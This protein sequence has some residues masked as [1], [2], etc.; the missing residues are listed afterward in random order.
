MNSYTDIYEIKKDIETKISEN[1]L[2]KLKL[3]DAIL[4]VL[5]KVGVLNS[6]LYTIDEF[7]EKQIIKDICKLEIEYTNIISFIQESIKWIF[8]WCSSYCSDS[9]ACKAESVK[10][11]DVCELMGLAYSYEKFYGMWEMHNYKKVNYSRKDKELKFEY[12]NEDTYKVHLFYDTICIM[13]DNARLEE[14]LDNMEVNKKNLT[15]IMNYAHELDF[16]C[17]FDMEFD[18]FNL[19]E[20][21]LFSQSINEIIYRDMKKSLYYNTMLIIPGDTGIVCMSRIQLIKTLYKMTSMDIEKINK[22]INFFTYNFLDYKSDISLTYIIPILND[23]I[24]ISEA[25]FN[26]QRPEV[27]AMRLLA[28]RESS[29]YDLAQNKFECQE[30]VKIQK[31]INERYVVGYGKEKSQKNIP[32]MD[33]LVYDLISNNLQVI[34]LKYKIPID[35]AR[36]INNLD[37]MLDKGYKQIDEAKVYVEDR[38]Q[39]ILN[40]YFGDYWNGLIPSKVDYFVLTNYSIGTGS[41]KELPTK[42][43]Q[44]NDYIDLM[45]NHDGMDRVRYIINDKS[46]MMNII[47]R[48]SYNRVYIFEYE[49]LIPNYS[50]RFKN[51]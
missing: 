36:D 26:F 38:L 35:S 9:S 33:L 10:F 45:S 43:L 34:E 19:K 49:I 12:K 20:Y 4:V 30:R 13:H 31:G 48:K 2:F 50:M 14:K 23:K 39:Y 1:K 37:E 11:N 7:K 16:D 8:R 21:K 25:I 17:C 18:G 27:N 6:S 28:K 22:M 42:I 29:K 51:I 46:K 40:D 44:T 15:E 47:E 24:I 3:D 32:G 41:G 5:E